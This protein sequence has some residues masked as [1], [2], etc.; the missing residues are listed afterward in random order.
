MSFAVRTS[1]GAAGA[2][3]EL[4]RIVAQIWPRW[5]HTRILLRADSGFCREVLMTWCE[6][7]KLDYLFGLAKN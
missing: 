7:N 4:E 6:A 5:P 3:E 1:M 2:R